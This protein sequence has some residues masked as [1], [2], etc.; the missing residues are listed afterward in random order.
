MNRPVL[1]K[2][3]WTRNDNPVMG[4]LVATK[5]YNALIDELSDKKSDLAKGYIKQKL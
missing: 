2:F 4:A 1:V 3:F 5:L